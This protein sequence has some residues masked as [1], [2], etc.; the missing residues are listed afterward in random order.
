MTPT[1]YTVIVGL[2]AVERLVELVIARRNMRHQLDRGGIE[3]GAGHYPAMV[4]AHT[5]L[6]VGCVVETWLLDRTD[7]PFIPLLGF[8]MI[9]VLICSQALRYWV[10]ATL[11]RRWTT[12]VIVVP[13]DSRVETGPY[14]FLSHPNYLAVVA[15]GVALPLIYS[16]WITAIV[17]SLANAVLLATRIRIENTALR[18]ISSKQQAA[19]N[20]H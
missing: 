20:D 11:G 7:R 16:N 5:A 3:Y 14:R 9:A 17:F 6:L 4:L 2:V 10:V 12:R 19:S 1:A 18:A 13:G 8:P 15:E